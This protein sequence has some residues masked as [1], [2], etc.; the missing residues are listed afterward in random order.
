MINFFLCVLCGFSF[1]FFGDLVSFIFF[2]GFFNLLEL[3]NYTISHGLCC[4]GTYDTTTCTEKKNCRKKERTEP[5]VWDDAKVRRFRPPHHTAMMVSLSYSRV[6][7]R[8]PR[9]DAG[10]ATKNCGCPSEEW[11]WTVVVLQ[12]NGFITY[13]FP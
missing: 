1:F 6:L 13:S 9:K 7:R 12:V 4:V 8:R 5:T 10:F 3:K 2:L 11:V